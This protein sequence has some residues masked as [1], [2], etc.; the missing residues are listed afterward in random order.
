ML[1]SA[2]PLNIDYDA[3]TLGGLTDHVYMYV[4][5]PMP[6]LA[7]RHQ[8]P[9]GEQAPHVV[10]KWIEGTCV[11]DYADAAIAWGKY[12]DTATFRDDFLALVDDVNISNDARAA[13]VE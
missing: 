11:Q 10:Y 6:H 8:Q 5:M 3:T 4:H 2:A 9:R 12:T 1:S 13:R 7:T